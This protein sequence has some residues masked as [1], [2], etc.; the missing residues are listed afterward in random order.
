MP[1]TLVRLLRLLTSPANGRTHLPITLSPYESHERHHAYP[2]NGIN[3][4]TLHNLQHNLQYMHMHVCM[5]NLYIPWSMSKPAIWMALRATRNPPPA[6]G[7]MRRL[8]RST[9]VV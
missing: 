9:P 7:V 3:L 6:G 1:P 5:Y 4:H 2:T 8:S